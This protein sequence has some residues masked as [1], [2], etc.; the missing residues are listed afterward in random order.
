MAKKKTVKKAAQKS[1]KQKKVA[2]KPQIKQSGLIP[3]GDRVL[4]R[5]FTEE[6]LKGSNNFGI[7]LPESMTKEKSAQG[8]VLAVGPGKYDD[9]D[10]I[11]MRVSVGDRVIFSKYG[12]DEVEYKGEELYLLREDQLLAVIK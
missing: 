9:G 5:P 8:E 10:L 11:P 7:I 1:T 12:Y 2:A 3:L 4:I 6:D